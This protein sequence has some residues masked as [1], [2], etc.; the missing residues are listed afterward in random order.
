MMDIASKTTEAKSCETSNK[1]HIGG[2]DIDS[3]MILM[4]FFL[5]INLYKKSTRKIGA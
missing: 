3:F 2:K 4:Y 5:C 1:D